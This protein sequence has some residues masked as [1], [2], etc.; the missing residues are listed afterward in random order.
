MA[1]EVK[2]PVVEKP[3]VVKDSPEAKALRAVFEAY[4]ERNPKKAELKA[5]EFERKLAV[6]N[7]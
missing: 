1:E 2:K 6:L 7:Q 3:K 5:E 4:K